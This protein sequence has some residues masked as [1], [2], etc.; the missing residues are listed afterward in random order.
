MDSY[1]G[2]PESRV[3]HIV[4]ERGGYTLCGLRLSTTKA[5]ILSRGFGI[6][7]S[8]SGKPIDRRA[9]KHCERLATKQLSTSPEQEE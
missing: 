1:A 9:C 8:T 5:G 6:L 2:G 4:E 3:Y 7:L